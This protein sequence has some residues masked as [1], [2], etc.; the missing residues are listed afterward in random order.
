MRIPSN[1]GSL[2][3]STRH[4]SETQS[5]HGGKGASLAKEPK[6]AASFQKTNWTDNPLI[7]RQEL[8]ALATDLKNGL[9]TRDEANHRFVNT[10]VNNSVKGRLSERDLEKIKSDISEFFAT[11]PEFLRNLE[12]NLSAL[13]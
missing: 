3:R 9:I 1:T 6:E 10:V 7:S 13:A 2:N 5:V 11:D 12:K 8:M 4:V